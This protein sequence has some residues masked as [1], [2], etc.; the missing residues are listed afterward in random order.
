[1]ATVN[2][3]N[4]PLR[5]IVVVWSQIEAV[6]LP[7]ASGRQHDQHCRW[8]IIGLTAGAFV[9]IACGRLADLGKART[10]KPPRNEDQLAKSA[11][12]EISKKPD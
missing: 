1:M 12:T 5:S 6:S 10:R 3:A 11:P 4:H 9:M 2:G 8:M 7:K